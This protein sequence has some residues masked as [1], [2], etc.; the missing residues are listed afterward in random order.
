MQA[1]SLLYSLCAPV[2][3]IFRIMLFSYYCPCMTQ[4]ADKLS[5]DLYSYVVYS[6]VQALH[7]QDSRHSVFLFFAPSRPRTTPQL[8]TLIIFLIEDSSYQFHERGNN[9]HK[10]S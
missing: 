5:L 10:Q 6:S 7:S 9:Q 2:P 8:T 3:D 4:A 1:V